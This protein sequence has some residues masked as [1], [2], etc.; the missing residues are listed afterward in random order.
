MLTL[1]R[2]NKAIEETLAEVPEAR[3]LFEKM[4]KMTDN[5][6][7]QVVAEAL[8]RAMVGMITEA[9][10]EIITD[11]AMIVMLQRETAQREMEGQTIN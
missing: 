6:L 9:T 1:D 11:M 2:V 5:E 4:S 7:R 3:P 10:L 8:I